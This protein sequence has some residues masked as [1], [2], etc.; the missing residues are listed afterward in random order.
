[1]LTI[2]EIEAIDE[3]LWNK[4]TETFKTSLDGVQTAIFE[5]LDD[6]SQKAMVMRAIHDGRLVVEIGQFTTAGETA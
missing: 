6:S 3:W 5:S 1:M 2:E 4:A